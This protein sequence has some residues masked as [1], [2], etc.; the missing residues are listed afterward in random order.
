MSMSDCPKC[1]DTPCECGFMGYYITRGTCKECAKY[2]KSNC[3]AYDY[4][5]GTTLL[6][7]DSFCKDFEKQGE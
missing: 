7:K 3:E 5:E 6:D 1:W 4:E 2:N